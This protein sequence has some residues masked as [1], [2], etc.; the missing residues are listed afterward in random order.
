MLGQWVEAARDLHTASKLDHDEEIQAVLLK[1][2]CIIKEKHERACFRDYC[3]KLQVEPNVH[4]I[5]EHRRKYER[6]R[7]ERETR[8]AERERQ[9][10][11]AEAEVVICY[12]LSCDL[13]FLIDCYVFFPSRC[14]LLIQGARRSK[15]QKVN[16]L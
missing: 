3:K 7:R 8:I 10:R 15:L 6:L 1:V 11:R 2:R 12:T 4:K 5:E 9:R 13:L 14:R 16:L